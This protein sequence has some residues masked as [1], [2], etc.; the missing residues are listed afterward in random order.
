M[1]D[2]ATDVVIR[3]LLSPTDTALSYLH[4][5]KDAYTALAFL[6]ETPDVQAAVGE[7][8]GTGVLILD[9]TVLL[10][11]FAETL[12]SPADRRYTSLLLG[13]RDAGMQLVVTRGVLNELDTHLDRCQRCFTMPAHAW[14]GEIPFV[15]RHWSEVEQRKEGFIAFIGQFRGER[16]VEDLADFL[17][18]EFGIGRI[19]LSEATDRVDLHTRG[20]IAELWRQKKLTTLRPGR[21]ESDLDLLL[22]HDVEMYFGCLGLREEESTNVFG[23]ETWWVTSDRSAVSVFDLGAE[24]GLRLSSNPCM[25]PNFLLS[26]LAI[27]PS[28]R[29]LEPSVRR[30]LPVALDM[31]YLGFGVP[32]LTS[33]ADEIREKYAG[34]RRFV[35]RR[36]TREAM[37]KLKGLQEALDAPLLDEELSPSF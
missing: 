6:R 22:R 30:L 26:L 23:Y 14:H 19:D 31:Q 32:G 25:S 34:K 7:L 12:Q 18:D 9:T 21:T 5:L 35:I 16:P 2:V 36:E 24:E 10:P 17:S 4:A 28:R 20:R 1:T 27:G 33:L 13:A 3:T 29:R 15:L 37:D 11:C 8:F